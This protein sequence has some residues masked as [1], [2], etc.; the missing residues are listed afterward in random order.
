MIRQVLQVVTTVSV[1]VMMGLSLAHAAELPGKRRLNREQY[2]A[3]QTIYYPG[4]TVGGSAEPLSILLLAG[5]AFWTRGSRLPFF[6]EI[7]ALIAA[8]AVQAVFWTCTQ[9]VNRYW[10]EHTGTS[11]SARAFFRSVDSQEARPDWRVLRDRWEHSHLWRA[12]LAMAAFVLLVTALS[13]E[14]E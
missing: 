13:V 12:G 7:G 4:F 14:A 6:L 3:V 9:P 10:L 5:L 1:G 11:K 2:L 8:I